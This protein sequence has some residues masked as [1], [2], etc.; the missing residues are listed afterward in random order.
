KVNVSYRITVKGLAVG[1]KHLYLFV[2]TGKCGASPAAEFA[3]S[4]PTG[5]ASGYYVPTANGRFT[6]PMDFRTSVRI[7]D[8]VCAYLTNSSA[9]EN[10]NKGVVAHA[11]KTYKVVRPR[12]GARLLT[13]ELLSRRSDRLCAFK[14]FP[15]RTAPRLGVRPG[16]TGSGA[17]ST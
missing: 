5:T 8:H 9:P 13:R 11:F 3:R 10:S 17:S 12:R 7:S 15:M 14:S 16:T 6:V 1:R 4:G 2:E